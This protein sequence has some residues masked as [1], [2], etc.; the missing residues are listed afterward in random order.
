M[1]GELDSASLRLQRLLLVGAA[2]MAAVCLQAMLRHGWAREGL[3]LSLDLAGLLVAGGC[4]L[5][6]WRNRLLPAGLLLI[7]GGALLILLAGLL[8][9]RP[10]AGTP[11]SAH[12]Y[13]LPLMLLSFELLAAQPMWQRVAIQLLLSLLFVLL[14][15]LPAP[16]GAPRFD[17]DTHALQAWLAV[18]LSLSLLAGLA[19]LSDAAWLAQSELE[20]DL[21]RAIAAGRLSLALQPQCDADEIGRAH[22]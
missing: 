8:I 21:A 14:A 11:R 3:A 16:A 10:L 5:L 1:R 6:A 9:D 20:L 2:L 15:G 7:A 17:P 19:H 18:G 13:L 4:A 12:L 22:V